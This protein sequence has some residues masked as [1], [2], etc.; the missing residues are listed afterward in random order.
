LK[1]ISIK[2]L[3]L[4]S[5]AS[6]AII[7]I[8]LTT[9]HFIP[10]GNHVDEQDGTEVIYLWDNGVHI[11]IVIKE[12]NEYVAYG[13]GSKIF[14]TQVPSWDDLTIK[15]GFQALFTKPESVIRVIKFNSE[16]SVDDWIPV[17]VTKNQLN[18]IRKSIYDTFKTYNGERIK[19]KGNLYDAHGN[20]W[21]GYTCNTWVNQILKKAGL[22][23]P[24][25][26]ISSSAIMR[27]QE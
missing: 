18:V 26:S 4:I 5:L 20:Y 14:L 7:V 22:K 2:N 15:I 11:D 24:L 9:L 19:V 6:I 1:R 27:Q 13:W 12:K 21:F 10:V 16:T 3:G 23:V 8:T 17:R 25:Y